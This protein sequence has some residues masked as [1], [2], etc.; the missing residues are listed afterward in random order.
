MEQSEHK[1]NGRTYPEG[2]AS[3]EK[4]HSGLIQA[5]NLRSLTVA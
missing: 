1:F 3:M 5:Y 2:R 4:L